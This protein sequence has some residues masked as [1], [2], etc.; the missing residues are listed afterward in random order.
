MTR[1]C[2]E[3]HQNIKLHVYIIYIYIYIYICIYTHLGSEQ[4]KH[5]LVLLTRV[6]KIHAGY[7]RLGGAR[8]LLTLFQ[9]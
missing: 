3:N 1:I 9:P 8:C 7:V 2:I 4:A 6:G 5:F